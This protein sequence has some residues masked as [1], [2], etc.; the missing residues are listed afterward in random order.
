MTKEELGKLYPVRIVAYDPEWPLLFEKEKQSLLKVLG[1]DL[2][3]RIE[4]M[5]STAV[6]GMVA[7]PT[8]DI[9]VEI[10]ET[11]DRHTIIGIMVENGYIH[12]TEQKKH[13]MLVKGYTPSGLAE[14]S[15]HIHMGPGNQ[16]WLW[17][18]LYFR[19][20]LREHADV[21]RR[22]EKLK[23]ELFSQFEHDREAYTDGKE[24]FITEI[25][26]LAKQVLKNVD[27]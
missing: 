16:D 22:Y 25:T 5:G 24:A 19:D 15:F 23:Q 27:G 2:A 21:A 17:D 13:L 4:H 6:P 9:L 3:L 18:R 26:K 11:A 1:T 7:K 14:E 12:M 8:I 20:Y 10:P